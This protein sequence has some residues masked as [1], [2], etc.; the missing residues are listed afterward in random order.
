[1]MEFFKGTVT[2]KDWMA[3][4]GILGV[5]TALAIGFYAMAHTSKLEELVAVQTVDA[6]KLADLTQARTINAQIGDLRD[7]TEQI[8]TLVNDFEERLPS[9]REIVELLEDFQRMANDS[10]MKV[11]FAPLPRE[12][13]ALKETIPYQIAARGDFHQIATFINR[14]ERFKR[15]L[16]VSNIHISPS[17]TDGAHA[18]FTL[19]TYR[20]LQQD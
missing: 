18:N 1:M 11:D 8:E 10:N 13:D 12:R 3:V 9:K 14:L 19:N 6:Q 17:E 20:F 7:E 2:P 5:T 15:Y 16:K 4:A